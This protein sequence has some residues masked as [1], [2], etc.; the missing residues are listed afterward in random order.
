M[1]RV[2]HIFTCVC[3]CERGREEEEREEEI[4]IHFSW[5]SHECRHITVEITMRG[6]DDLTHVAP[7]Q[8]L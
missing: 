6:R 2:T 4:F 8:Q 1:T 3:V 5:Q 7:L